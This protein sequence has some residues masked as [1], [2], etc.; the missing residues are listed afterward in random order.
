MKKVLVT[1]N[2]SSSVD[3]PQPHPVLVSHQIEN[4]RVV[5]RRMKAAKSTSLDPIISQKLQQ[6]GQ[7]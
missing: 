3:T 4:L 6:L 1:K 7:H 5:L 2:S